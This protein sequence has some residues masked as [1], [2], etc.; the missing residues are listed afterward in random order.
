MAEF[1]AEKMGRLSQVENYRFG[2]GG[3]TS[4]FAIAAA[5][6]GSS[7]GYVCKLGGDEFGLSFLKIW[8][9][10]GVDSSRV[11]VEEG[12][13]TAVYFISLLK[14]GGHD[15]TYYRK[16]SAASHFSVEDLDFDYLKDIRALHTS[17]I[18][19][20][21]SPSLREACFAAMEACKEYGG[22]LS[23]DVNM[24]AKLWLLEDARSYCE[25]AIHISDIVFASIEDMK[26]LYGISD[27]LEA[28]DKIRYLGANIVVIKLGGEGCLVESN[29]ESFF[30]PSFDIEVIDTTGSGDAFDGAFLTALIED[31]PLNS[32]A[33]FAN[34][35]GALTATSLGA[36]APIPSRK[37]ALSIMGG[38]K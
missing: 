5:R 4:N 17:G 30:S 27:P 26:I 32:M 3:D 22:L 9:K 11:M 36:V 23:F 19:L 24:R 10:E 31:R 38:W 20:A 25:R 12:G 14:E 37:E 2:W 35:Y 21:V 7:V 1:C 13:I 16:D 29:D 18:S 28:A 34:A 8:D 33:K 15:F 6:A